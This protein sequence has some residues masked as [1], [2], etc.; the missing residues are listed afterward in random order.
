MRWKGSASLSAAPQVLHNTPT[1]FIR[2]GKG[3]HRTASFSSQDIFWGEKLSL[4]NLPLW[5]LRA[6]KERKQVSFKGNYKYNTEYSLSRRGLT[7]LS[8]SLQM[9]RLHTE[10]IFWVW[11]QTLKTSAE[12]QQIIN[13]QSFVFF[14]NESIS[15]VLV[16]CLMPIGISQNQRHHLH[17]T[18]FFQQ[19]R[20][21][22]K[23]FQLIIKDLRCSHLWGFKNLNSSLII[24]FFQTR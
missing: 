18:H 15:C 5:M 16:C 7:L 24:L 9:S 3:W 23:G 22:S 6:W 12:L 1:C 8:F 2:H 17:I 4:K 20:P 11:A 19:K 13:L 21:K 14:V 10:E